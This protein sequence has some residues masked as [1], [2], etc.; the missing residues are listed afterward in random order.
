MWVWALCL[1]ETNTV[2]LSDEAKLQKSME[3]YFQRLA[4][5]KPVTRNNYSI[6]VVSSV[7]DDIDPDELGWSSSTNG[8]EDEFE[9]ERYSQLSTTPTASNLRLRVE[10]QTLR[11]LPGCGAIAFGIRTYLTSVEEL[12]SEAGERL[13]SSVEGWGEDI[14]IYKGASKWWEVLQN[15]SKQE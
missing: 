5:D 10:R 2:C 9:D 4:V 14:K 6:Q 15:K 8:P 12:S 7:P 11:R 13:V 3:R 1:G